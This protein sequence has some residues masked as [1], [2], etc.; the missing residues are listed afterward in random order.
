MLNIDGICFSKICQDTRLFQCFSILLSYT[1]CLF[2]YNFTATNKLQLCKM[3]KKFVT[4]NSKVLA[5][6]DGLN[7]F[8]MLKEADVSVGILS[9]L[10]LMQ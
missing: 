4:K 6:G 1:T 10:W 8:M 7:D 9:P 5:I 3:L 2:A